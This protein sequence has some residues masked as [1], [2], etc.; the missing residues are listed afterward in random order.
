LHLEQPRLADQLGRLLARDVLV[1]SRL[2]LRGRREDRLGK[3]VRLAQAFGQSMP[4]DFAASAVVLPARPGEIAADDALD[5][6]HLETAALHRA[7]VVADGEHVVRDD[8]SEG[9]EPVAREARQDTPL[10]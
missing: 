5:R 3:L 8:R 9:R 2:R 4:T 6:E 1:V 10:V 7:A